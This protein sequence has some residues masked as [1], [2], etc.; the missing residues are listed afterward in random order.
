QVRGHVTEH[1]TLKGETWQQIQTEG[2][3]SVMVQV[4]FGFG[5]KNN[6]F[7]P[8]PAESSCL[9][10]RYRQDEDE[11]A[12]RIVCLHSVDPG[13][14]RHR[15][16]KSRDDVTTGER[17]HSD[18]EDKSRRRVAAEVTEKR[19]Q[20][21]NNVKVTPEYKKLLRCRF[22][23]EEC[24]EQKCKSGPV[25][26]VF[27]IDSSRSV[28]P[29]EFET[30]RKF[31]IDILNT[32]DIG[33]NATRV[34]VVQYSSQFNDEGEDTACLYLRDD[35]MV[36]LPSLSVGLSSALLCLQVRTE[37]SLKAHAKLDSM[38]KGNQ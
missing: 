22:M 9:L 4:R 25:D 37:F 33:L 2:V 36:Y 35:L 29:H 6:S 16:A 8:V 7:D 5:T 31:M 17:A 15:Q 34:G 18:A 11:T 13:R 21:V 3:L 27:L 14:P 26:L 23:R 12:R 1:V 20:V 38:V 32:L 30:M 24:P 19:A 10:D 28:R